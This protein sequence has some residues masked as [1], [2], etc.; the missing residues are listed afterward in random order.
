MTLN[1]LLASFGL[2]LALLAAIVGEPERDDSTLEEIA[3][4]I[5]SEEDHMTPLELAEQLYSGKKIRLIDIRDSVSHFEQHI[6]NSELMSI[7]QLLK[8]E[9]RKNELTVLYFEGGI[10]ASQAWMLMKMKHY[11]NIYTLLGGFNGWK[12]IV[13]NP[14]LHAGK[15]EEEKK[16]FE[17]RKTLSR[18]FG[19]EPIDIPEEM[20]KKNSIHQHQSLPKNNL[21]K[22]IRKSEDELRFQC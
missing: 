14:T 21:P 19:G 22:K 16:E 9:I 18:F 6:F 13:L 3:L 20:S 10:H 1:K 4:L 12:E 2:I 5:Q 7:Q 15:T 8:N 11:D 17:R